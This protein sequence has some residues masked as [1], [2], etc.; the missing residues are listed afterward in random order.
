MENCIYHVNAV[1]LINGQLHY[2]MVGKHMIVAEKAV[3]GSS[4]NNIL[5]Y[6]LAHETNL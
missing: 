4:L 5:Q 6:I 2:S 1:L 3:C